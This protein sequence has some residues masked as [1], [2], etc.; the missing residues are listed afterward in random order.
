MHSFKQTLTYSFLLV[1]IIVL[2]SCQ[3]DPTLAEQSHGAW[4]DNT[5]IGWCLNNLNKYWVIML[6]MTIDSSF[7]PFPSEIV[8]IP[9]AYLS[10]A[11][12]TAAMT[13]TTAPPSDL[14]LF[15]IVLFGTLGSI[16]GALINYALSVWLGRPIIYKFANSRLGHVCLLDEEKVHKSE[17][18]FDK[19]GA[20]GT[21]FGRLVPA[22][23][24]LISIPAGLS[25]MNIFKFVAYTALG[26]ALWNSILAAMG[27]YLATIVSW[28]Q[29]DQKIEEYSTPLKYAMLGLG[30]LIVLYLVWQG[31]KAP[32]QKK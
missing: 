2:A 10:A 21:F 11:S 22:V 25:R 24:Q 16:L 27:A 18:Y 31:M 15:L 5:F 4:F 26:S 7:I 8:V 23:R 12:T 17:Q 13:A 6:L 28:E 20:M 3:Q 32:K 30:A 19:H 14:N 1:G 29:L 9:A